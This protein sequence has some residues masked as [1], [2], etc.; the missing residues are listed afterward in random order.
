MS[1]P[2]HLTVRSLSPAYWYLYDA[3]KAKRESGRGQIGR[4]FGTEVEARAVLKK[5]A[6]GA[7]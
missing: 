2:A 4:P 6:G 1:T 5:M 3:Q 7:A